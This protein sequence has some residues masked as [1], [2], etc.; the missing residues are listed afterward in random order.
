MYI[1]S[2]VSDSL[3]LVRHG[4]KR[5]CISLNPLCK[6][7]LSITSS[8]KVFLAPTYMSALCTGATNIMLPLVAEL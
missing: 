7:D 2:D 4:K 6:I 1:E 3:L 8:L 5:I